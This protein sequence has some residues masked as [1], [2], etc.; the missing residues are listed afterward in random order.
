MTTSLSLLKANMIN[1]VNAIMTIKLNNAI[2]IVL[3]DRCCNHLKIK[4]NTIASTAAGIAP[5]KMRLVSLRSIPSNIKSPSPPAP[6]SAAS[7]AVPIINTILVRIP[8][9]TT[10]IARGNST[11]NNLLRLFIPIPRAASINEGSTSLIPVYVFRSIG[12][13]A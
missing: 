5:S 10:G 4:S 2:I 12:S 8:A 7:V 13:N 9:I 3:N 11:C 1:I 6:I